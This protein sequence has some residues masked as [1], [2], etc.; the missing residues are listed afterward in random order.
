MNKLNLMS[1]NVSFRNR[2]LPILW[3]GQMAQHVAENYIQQPDTHPFLHIEIQ[4]ACMFV[5]I[6]EKHKNASS[7][8]GYSKIN[9]IDVVVV[10]EI[11]VNFV[12]IKSC[13]KGKE[14][15]MTG[16]EISG[17]IDE[18]GLSYPDHIYQEMVDI[19]ANKNFQEAKEDLDKSTYNRYVKPYLKKKKTK[20]HFKA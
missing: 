8:R 11:K 9:G 15:K 10:I 18:M 5:R 14:A 17:I 20:V 7:Y 19:G 12:I 2:K 6:W 3:T 16:A 4:Q 1:G 13:F